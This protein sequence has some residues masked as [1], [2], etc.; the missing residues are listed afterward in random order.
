MRHGHDETD[1]VFVDIDAAKEGNALAIAD[2]ERYGDVR[3]FGDFASIDATMRRV[4]KC[5]ADKHEHMHYC[6]EAGPTSRWIVRA[7]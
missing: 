4:V 3:Y 1:E 2:G 5:S 7:W 6:C